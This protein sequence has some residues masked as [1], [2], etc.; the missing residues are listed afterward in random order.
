MATYTCNFT[1]PSGANNGSKLQGPG[2]NQVPRL[3]SGD[4]V[5]I[6]VQWGGSATSAPPNL[7][8]RFI[9]SPAT[10]ASGNQSAPSPF[11]SGSKY[12]CYTDQLVNLDQ[13]AGSVTYTFQPVVYGGSQ[14]GNYEL[15]F[16]AED[17]RTPVTQWSEDPEF[18]TDP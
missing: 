2:F 15:T 7:K 12:I 9:F 14:G 10:D 17:P 11:V 8:G 16:V 5:Q 18:D 4:S 1:I 6:K 3:N 13:G